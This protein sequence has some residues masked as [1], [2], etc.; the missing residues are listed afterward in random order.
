MTEQ[1]DDRIVKTVPRHQMIILRCKNHPE[2]RW[3]TKNIE[4]IGARSIFYN[5]KE[6]ECSCK[7]KDLEPLPEQ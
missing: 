5:S 1:N 7:A 3:A 4:Y 6:P 2:L